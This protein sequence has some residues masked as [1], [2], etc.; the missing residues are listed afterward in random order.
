M[1]TTGI[2]LAFRDCNAGAIAAVSCG[3]MAMPLTPWLM[4]DCTL[5]V[6]LATSFWELV[7]LSDSPCSAANWGVYLMYEFQKSV[8]D[9]G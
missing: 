4:N 3:A 9:L 8:S 5:A 1:V 2:F 6:S 7:V